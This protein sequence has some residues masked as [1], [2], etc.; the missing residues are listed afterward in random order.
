MKREVRA[1][2]S[3]VIMAVWRAPRVVWASCLFS[4]CSRC[5]CQRK[6]ELC[7]VLLALVVVFQDDPNS[8]KHPTLAVVSS[9]DG[10]Y[11][12]QTGESGGNKLVCVNL[13]GYVDHP[14]RQ[15]Y[16]GHYSRPCSYSTSTI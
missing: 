1:M 2:G 16:K 7:Q 4:V 12:V 8:K 13:E 10:I 3:K 14:R 9:K 11:K 6:L 5:Y 15:T